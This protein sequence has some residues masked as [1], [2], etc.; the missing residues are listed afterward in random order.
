MTDCVWTEAMQVRLLKLTAESEAL[1][2]QVIADKL[3][4]EFGTELTRNACIGKARRLDIHKK[5]APSFATMVREPGYVPK[6]ER[7]KPQR[8]NKV[9]RIPIPGRKPPS[10]RADGRRTLVD[11]KSRE[12]RWAFGD[13]PPYLFCGAPTQ[14]GS[15]CTEHHDIVYHSGFKRRVA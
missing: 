4:T 2:Y 15:Y 7:V 9:A 10:G 8:A 5:P 6:R 12:C 11:L 1:S 13:D 3:N 14:G